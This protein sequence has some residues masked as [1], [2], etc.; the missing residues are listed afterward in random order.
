VETQIAIDTLTDERWQTEL[1]KAI[2]ADVMRIRTQLSIYHSE[3]EQFHSDN[4]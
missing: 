3:S 2:L 1:G 4:E